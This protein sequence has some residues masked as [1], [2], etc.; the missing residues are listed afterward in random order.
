MKKAVI[1]IEQTRLLSALEQLPPA[2]LKRIID[3][4]FLK[5]FL[6]KPDYK[7][8]SARAK[9]VVRREKLAPEI[10]EETIQWARNQE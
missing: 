3:T 8:V 4:L 2:E 1:Q 7:D 5:R 6:K 10:A 9:K